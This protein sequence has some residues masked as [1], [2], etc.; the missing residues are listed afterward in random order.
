MSVAFPAEV[1]SWRYRVFAST[2][3]C[4]VGYYFCRKPFYTAKAD[5]GVALDLDAT[6]L[7]NIGAAYS[8]AYMVGHFLAGGLGTRFGARVVL[9]AGMTASIGLNVAMGGASTGTILLGLMT[10][11]G[12]AQATGWSNN[13][14]TMAA[15][16]H[17][18]E[19]GRVMGLW[20]TN[21]TT[22]SLLSTW[23]AS[24]VIGLWGY[25]AS[26]GVG[27]A[28]LGA[29]L[30]FFYFNQRNKPE[31][32]GFAR[33]EDPSHRPEANEAPEPTSGPLF[34]RQALI[35]VLLIG[36]F[37]FFLKFIRY[38]VW[39]WAPFLLKGRFGLSSADAGIYS[40]LFEIFGVL[41]T[42]TIGFLSDKVFGGRRALVSLWMTVGLAF[43]CGV[44]FQ[45]GQESL[46]LFTICLGLVGFFLFGPDA[47]MT[48][49]GAIDVSTRR[50]ATAA[51]GIISGL[52]AIGQVVQDP[53]IGRLYDT[54]GGEIGGII[55][56]LFGSAA[57]AAAAL[58][59]LVWRAQK[60]LARV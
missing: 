51:S 43:A 54:G 38:A 59:V 53:I 36:G 31:D 1:Q 33:I 34:T 57:C 19:R 47:L 6:Y 12:L 10:L 5:L 28:V 8:M 46:V 13:V 60:G 55:A 24:S 48:G 30:V 11:N 2:W 17:R 15:W 26:F 41:G 44:F 40:T 35:N 9:M 49:A 25:Q 52:G 32:L 58:G 16:F 39:S 45:Y 27:A 14:G 20:S 29:V 7:G 22:G 18:L 3:L 50:S 23:V 21:F 56:F 37:Y 42:I 4:Y